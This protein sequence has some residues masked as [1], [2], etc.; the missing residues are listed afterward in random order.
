[1]WARQGG[2]RQQQ[3]HCCSAHF[4]LSVCA[5]QARPPR[6]APA[7]LA[8][9]MMAATLDSGAFQGSVTFTAPEGPV[10]GKR[11]SNPATRAQLGWQPKYPSYAGACT[12]ARRRGARHP[13]APWDRPASGK[14][15]RRSHSCP[16]LQCPPALQTSCD[17]RAPKTGTPPR[18]QPWR[19]CRT[20][21]AALPGRS[22]APDQRARPGAC[23][24]CCQKLPGCRFR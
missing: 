21:R 17:R 23:S 11:M 3:V 24:R 9:D 15:R 8:Q 6:F 20:R 12:L 7:H 14:Q 19:A 22:P 5:L 10:K 18:R 2:C 1:M 16:L 4:L 13:V